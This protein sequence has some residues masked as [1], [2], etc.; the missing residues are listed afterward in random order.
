[1]I[2]NIL[3]RYFQADGF[4]TLDGKNHMI[5]GSTNHGTTTE[6]SLLTIFLWLLSLLIVLQ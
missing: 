4:T 5:C 6:R 1:M 2:V 3:T